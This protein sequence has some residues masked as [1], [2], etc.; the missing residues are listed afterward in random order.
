MGKDSLLHFLFHVVK[1]GCKIVTNPQEVM[2]PDQIIM[3]QL[4]KKEQD[5]KAVD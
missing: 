5:R 4:E 2:A 3:L 1:I